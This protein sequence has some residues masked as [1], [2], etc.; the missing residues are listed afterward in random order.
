MTPVLSVNQLSKVFST[1]G[2]LFARSQKLRAV[3]G[4]AFE[5]IKG[6]TLAL[7]GESGCGKSTLAK[8]IAA[9]IAPT[10]GDIQM[11]GK[12]ASRKDLRG[13]V[14]M[15]FQDPY[16][17][18]NPRMR[19]GR[20]IGE[21]LAVH[22]RGGRSER[23]ARVAA[24][25]QDVGLSL[26]DL[27]RFPHQFSGGQRQR[28]AIARTIALEPR[29]IIADEPTSALDVSIQSQIL[30]LMGD[31]QA[32]TGVAYLFISHNLS[33]VSH[34]ADRIAVMYYGEIV[35]MGTRD[36]VL[37]HPA[38]PYTRALLNAAP[39]LGRGKRTP[40]TALPG[41]PPSLFSPPMGCPFRSRCPVAI[42]RCAAEA[43]ILQNRDGHSV[44][45]H[46][47]EGET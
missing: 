5:L 41:E 11:D 24:L 29:V 35:E 2:G 36:A 4:V 17:S 16:A 13:G 21:P 28:I 10:S 38:H 42:D 31:I 25:A 23:Q 1:G 7:V 18:L 40:G 47:V 15:V 43:P 12:A 33:V 8:M 20:I 9:L 46:V 34:M 6:E 27:E 37:E 30:N 32:R 39:K 22:S 45:C 14:Q 19:V 3:R 44:A 26:E